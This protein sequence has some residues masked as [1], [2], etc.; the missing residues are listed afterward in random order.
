MPAEPSSRPLSCGPWRSYRRP[1][2]RPGGDPVQEPFTAPA[3]CRAEG[4]IRT[5]DDLHQWRS[6]LSGA[7]E[8]RDRGLRALFDRFD[9]TY[10]DRTVPTREGDVTLGILRPGARRSAPFPRSTTSTGAG[11]SSGPAIRRW[12][13]SACSGFLVT[14]EYTLAPEARAPRA[15]MECDSALVYLAAHADEFMIDPSRIIL[16]GISGGGGLAAG[17]GLLARD[18]GGPQLLGQMLNCPRSSTTA[19]GRPRRSSSAQRGE[20][21]TPG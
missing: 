16:S 10:E 14:P 13:R 6:A 18:N 12:F 2:V 15:A 11:W 20:R 7:E 19:T 21:S 17:V 1:A 9:L 3:D 8:E 5:D 4:G